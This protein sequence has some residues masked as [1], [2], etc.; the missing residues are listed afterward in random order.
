MNY[1]RYTLKSTFEFEGVGLHSGV[2]VVMK[3]H[4][5]SEGIQFL[6]EGQRTK[7]HPENVT[8]T[9]RCTTLGNVHTVEHIMSAFAGLG[10]T[11]ADVELSANEIPGADGSAAPFVNGLSRAEIEKVADAELPGLFTRV[12]LQDDLIKIAIG[13][14]TGHWRFEYETGTRWPGSMIYE[15]K[16][17]LAD[18]P[19][20]ISSARTFA[21]SEEL[22]KIIELG[23]G[24][25]LDESSALVIGIEGFKN[26]ARFEDE[27]ARHKLLDLVGDLYLSGVPIHF[28]NVVGHRSG[29]RTNV[30]AAQMLASAVGITA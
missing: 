24:R 8:E 3:V 17:V 13:K 14:G 10:I 25:G 15:S 2:P 12:F 30:K 7:A 11:D 19:K 6:C 1:T 4:P 26:E 21:L 22:P 16:D 20:E 27:P 28:L 18:Y 29:H 23:L 9:V 5:S